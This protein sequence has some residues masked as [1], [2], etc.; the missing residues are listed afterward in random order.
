MISLGYDIGS[1]FVKGTVFDL[2]EGRELVTVQQPKEEM[3][4]SSPRQDWAEQDPKMWWQNFS[5]VTQQLIAHA[6]VDASAVKSIGISYQ[7]HGLVVVDKQLNPL[8]PAIIWCDSRAA[9][10]GKKAYADIGFE[11]IQNHCCPVNRKFN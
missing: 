3:P 2:E 8:R 1:S 9:E 6:D 11:K 5:K 7:M 10:I 4:I